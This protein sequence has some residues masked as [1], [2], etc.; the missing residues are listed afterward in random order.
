MDGLLAE[1]HFRLKTYSDKCTKFDL[2]T[3]NVF[4]YNINVLVL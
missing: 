1:I 3:K 4:Y 2:Y